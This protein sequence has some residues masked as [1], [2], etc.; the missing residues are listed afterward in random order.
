M[1]HPSILA[2][3]AALL[4]TACSPSFKVSEM[5]PEETSRLEALTQRMATRCVGRYLIDLPE[6]FVLNPANPVTVEGIPIKVT[7]MTR[8]QFDQ[9]LQEREKELRSEHMDGKPDRPLLKGLERVP[10]GFVGR[11]FNRV[12][13][14]G[15]AEF[16]RMLEL[17][18]WKNGYRIDM[19]IK[20]TDGRDLRPNPQNAGTVWENIEKKTIEEYKNRNDTPEKLAHLLSLYERVHGRIESVIPWE[21][22]L[23]ISNGF[24]S[25]PAIEEEGLSMVFDLKGS[26]DVYFMLQEHGDLHE[27]KSLLE[28]SGQVEQ[29]M[30]ESGT[31]TIR[32]GKKDISGQTF[33]EWL[34]NGPTPDRVQ[35]TMFALH[36]NEVAKGADRPFVILELFN[37]FR[38]LQPSDLSDEQK[39][40]LG[41][42]R[43]LEKA[44]FSPAIALA[45]WDK[46][47]PTL[48]RRP[49]A[50]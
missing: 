10:D 35:G 41:L 47:I 6:D 26:P 43:D 29:E 5:T 37:G 33:E 21:K 7:P 9:E 40:R 48:R 27:E 50:F 18:A 42:Y 4:L 36:G 39:E 44:T 15:T 17:I 38:V 23:C 32:K 1:M 2:A 31:Q 22:G 8:S 11:I 30:K 3:M 34:W 46:V 28:R 16:G 14:S 19:E 25:G 12:E 24:V 45:L 20:A 49:G 13:S